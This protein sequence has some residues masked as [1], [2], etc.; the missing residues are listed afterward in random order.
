MRD[1]TDT[2]A[3]RVQLKTERVDEIWLLVSRLTSRPDPDEVPQLLADAR[4]ALVDLLA[5][6]DDLVRVNAEAG[7]EVTRWTGAGWRRS[8]TGRA[9][10]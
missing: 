2:E 3:R 4:T 1:T 9:T 6:R 7:A 5:N 10:R 8:R